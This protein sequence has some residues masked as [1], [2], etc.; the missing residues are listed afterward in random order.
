MGWEGSVAVRVLVDAQGNAADV[1]VLVGSGQ[2]VL[3]QSAVA[4]V[5]RWKFLPAMEA[6][7]PVTM[8]H[9]LHIRFRLDD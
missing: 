2:D 5:R 4:T 8:V 7:K 6:G 3:D 9:D 1:S